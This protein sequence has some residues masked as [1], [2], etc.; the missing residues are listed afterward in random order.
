[1]GSRRRYSKVCCESGLY[2]G[3]SVTDTT[4]AISAH[5]TGLE[6][7]DAAPGD[8]SISS[9]GEGASRRKPRPA[10]RPSLSTP[11][12]CPWSLRAPF[13]RGL[14]TDARYQR[15]LD[16]FTEKVRQTTPMRRVLPANSHIPL[17][18]S[19]DIMIP[20]LPPQQWANWS[21]YRP[22]LPEALHKD[23]ASVASVIAWLSNAP[24][25]SSD[26]PTVQRYA[27]VMGLFIRDCV[28]CIELDP[29]IK[30]PDDDPPAYIF[31]S[32]CSIATMDSALEIA[33]R[34]ASLAESA[35]IDAANVGVLE[36]PVQADSTMPRSDPS[37]SEVPPPKST[38]GRGGRGG[39]GKGSRSQTRGRGV[40]AAARP[41]AEAAPVAE[42]PAE[43]TEG[44]PRRSART[45]TKTRKAR[46][47]EE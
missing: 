3:Y 6:P 31:S 11:A 40:A 10:K 42:G 32:P 35:A 34:C 23:D 30:Y 47:A 22:H 9:V 5:L 28:T 4:P 18:I 12:R 33:E 26:A 19:A 15:F 17:K 46:E 36:V 1:M 43:P 24:D 16:A 41:P 45:I 44:A 13:L 38:R 21:Y 7:D 27:L 39:R 25:T 37:A 2:A 14:S 8:T 29:T 20:S